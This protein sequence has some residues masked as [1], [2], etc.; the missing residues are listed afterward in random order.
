MGRIFEQFIGLELLRFAHAKGRGTKIRFWRD[1]DGPEVDWV[2]DKDGAYTP[3]EVKL[4]AHP[5]PGDIKHT[6]VFLSEYKTAK[7]GFIVC[8]VPRK[9]KLSERVFALPWQAISEV[10][11]GEAEN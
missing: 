1:P 3:L 6:E 7:Q 11:A 2:I 10:L 9:L 4:T 5:A 8:Q